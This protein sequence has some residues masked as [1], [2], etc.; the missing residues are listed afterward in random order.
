M[1]AAHAAGATGAVRAAARSAVT[2]AVQARQ[3]AGP[4]TWA[5]LDTLAGDIAAQVR[6]HGEMSAIPAAAVSNVRNDMYL[7]SEAIRLAQKTDLAGAGRR[8]C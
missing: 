5:A 6:A 1:F 4:Q 3:I 2:E 7:V 8:R